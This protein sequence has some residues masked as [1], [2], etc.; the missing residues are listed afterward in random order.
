[1]PGR[2]P[3]PLF[4]TG[5]PSLCGC[6]ARP[7]PPID[8]ELGHRGSVGVSLRPVIRSTGQMGSASAGAAW[9]VWSRPVRDSGKRGNRSLTP[10]LPLLDPGFE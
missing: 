7:A 1:M 4:A 6:A 10:C 2:L 5:A 9:D 3:L 8:H